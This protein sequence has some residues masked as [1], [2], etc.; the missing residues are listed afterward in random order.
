MATD[1]L[2]DLFFFNSAA[3]L[4]RFKFGFLLRD[5]LLLGAGGRRG[6]GLGDGLKRFGHG[7]KITDNC[8]GF[9]E[10]FL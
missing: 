3:V 5:L 1:E 9:L 10:V 7:K 2:G 6:E 4:L 8:T